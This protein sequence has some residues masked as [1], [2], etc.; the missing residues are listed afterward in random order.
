MF[1]PITAVARLWEISTHIPSEHSH[2]FIHEVMWQPAFVCW[3]NNSK[4]CEQILM[5]FS[6]TTNNW[7][8]KGWLNVPDSGGSLMFNLQKIKTKRLYLLSCVTLYQYCLYTCIL[9]YYTTILDYGC[10]NMWGNELLC[11]GLCSSSAFFLVCL[12]FLQDIKKKMI[13]HRNDV[14]V[15]GRQKTTNIVA[16]KSHFWSERETKFL[17]NKMKTS[18]GQLTPRLW[19]SPCSTRQDGMFEKKQEVWLLHHYVHT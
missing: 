19:V 9:D 16:G 2:A 3:Q 17:L 15:I 14:V 10:Y 7:P 1:Y 18:V 12:F 6:G 13:E 4:H 5:E 8:R 11:R